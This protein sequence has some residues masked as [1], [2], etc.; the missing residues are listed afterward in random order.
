MLLHLT[1][2]PSATSI[3]CHR[4]MSVPYPFSLESLHYYLLI[5]RCYLSRSINLPLSSNRERHQTP[6]NTNPNTS[7][8]NETWLPATAATPAPTPSV[9]PPPHHHHHHPS[10]QQLTSPRLPGRPGTCK[11]LLSRTN[12]KAPALLSATLETCP[13]LRAR[14]GREATRPP[15]LVS[16][17]SLP[18]WL[19]RT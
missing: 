10:W 17:P 1:F 19:R 3:Q 9:V 2:P 6:A 12:S 7:K 4:E 5:R 11:W 18:S 13:V 8:H 15:V 14:R 16:L